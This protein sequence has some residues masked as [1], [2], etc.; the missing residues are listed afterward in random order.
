MA[1]H[2]STGFGTGTMTTPYSSTHSTSSSWTGRTSGAIRG[3][4]QGYACQHDRAWGPGIRLNEHIEENG[5]IVFRHACS[6][7]CLQTGARPSMY[8]YRFSSPRAGNTM[9]TSP[10]ERE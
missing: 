10:E 8:D 2:P 7:D 6:A 5:P 3:S 9:P 4:A 1:S